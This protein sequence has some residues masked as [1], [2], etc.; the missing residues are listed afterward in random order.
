MTVDLLTEQRFSQS[1]ETAGAIN[2]YNETANAEGKRTDATER[3]L[4]QLDGAGAS[5]IRRIAEGEF[6]LD[7]RAKLELA[8]YISYQHFRVPIQRRFIDQ[9]AEHTLKLDIA[10]KG[11]EGPRR[12]EE[13]HGRHHSE[14]ELS[15]LWESMIAF[16]E[17]T[18]SPGQ[19]EHI[20]MG[21]EMAQEFVPVFFKRPWAL[22]RFELLRLA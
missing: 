4:S 9:V 21:L 1:V 15:A 14:D 19:N 16:D 7:P 3:A 13:A 2:N 12:I 22:V 20:K 6:P 18:F 11:P 8:S 17:Y 10:V 5:A